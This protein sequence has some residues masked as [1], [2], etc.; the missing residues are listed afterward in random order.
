[1]QVHDVSPEEGEGSN[2]ELLDA[3]EYW[4]VP[5]EGGPSPDNPV[6][7]GDGSVYSAPAAAAAGAPAHPEAAPA[8]AAPADL[9]SENGGSFPAENGHTGPVR[10]IARL[11]CLQSRQGAGTQ[12]PLLS[13]ARTEPHRFTG[14]IMSQVVQAACAGSH[15]VTCSGQTEQWQGIRRVRPA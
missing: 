2:F 3:I 8:A 15:A 6:P 1:M 5:I 14:S 12:A 10:S 13:N 4:E 7:A 11:F 9:F